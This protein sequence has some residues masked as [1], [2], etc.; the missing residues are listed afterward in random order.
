M[1]NGIFE[2]SKRPTLKSHAEEQIRRAIQRGNLKPGERIIETEIAKMLD[3][4]RYPVREAISSLERE[5]FLVTIPYKGTYVAEF[6]HEDLLEIYSLRRVLE[7]FAVELLAQRGGEKVIAE[8]EHI[9]TGMKRALDKGHM[10]DTIEADLSFHRT[11]C[12]FCGH[13]RLLTV[14]Q[15][16]ESQIRPLASTIRRLY[17][18]THP[19]ELIQ[20]HASI[21]KA[22]KSGDVAGTQ[23]LL[24]QH[25][26]KAITILEAGRSRDQV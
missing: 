1:I 4:S 22:L 10:Q 24:V 11:L 17:Y 6:S 18:T 2:K 25:F 14:W 3:I 21:L 7:G 5:G 23:T 19:Q 16:L 9:L 12:A 8:L 15:N 20:D 13:K 26:E